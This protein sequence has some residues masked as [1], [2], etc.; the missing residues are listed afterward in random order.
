MPDDTNI[1]V[2]AKGA[3]RY[4]FFYDDASRA[5]LLRTLGRFASNPELSFDWFDAATL[6]K[7]LRGEA[8]GN[9]GEA[10]GNR[11]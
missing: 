1:L 9:R 10:I 8:I 5:E 11:R 2:L 6:S 3:E 4:V 7:K